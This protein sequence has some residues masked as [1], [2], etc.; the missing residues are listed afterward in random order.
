MSRLPWKRRTRTRR[1]FNDIQA[2]LGATIERAE[3]CNGLHPLRDAM[4]ADRPHLEVYHDHLLMGVSDAVGSD[5]R[6]ATR[7]LGQWANGKP[8]PFGEIHRGLPGPHRWGVLGRYGVLLRQGENSH[9]AV[10]NMV[11]LSPIEFILDPEKLR[12]LQQ[13]FPPR[14][15]E[16]PTVEEISRITEDLVNGRPLREGEEE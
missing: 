11:W 10:L 5:P 7:W 9:Y 3:V 15:L 8:G 1:T 13:T 16:R 4:V 14:S 12:E 6:T 2:I